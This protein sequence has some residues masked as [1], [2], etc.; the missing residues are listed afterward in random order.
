MLFSDHKALLD[1]GEILKKKP[2]DITEYTIYDRHFSVN[3]APV[4]TVLLADLHNNSFGTDNEALVAAIDEI[5]PEIIWV[6]GDLMVAVPEKSIR[7]AAELMK[8]LAKSYPILYGIGNHEY[9]TRIYPETYGSMYEEYVD[10]LMDAG[11]ELLHNERRTLL[12]GSAEVDVYG[13]EMDRRYYKR[14]S[15]QRMEK[16]YLEEV[17]PKPRGDVYR[18][19]LAHHPKY[20]DT[21]TA[22]GADLTLSGHLHGGIV[23]LFGRGAVSPGLCPFPKY[24]GGRY[25]V[26]GRQLIVSRGLGSHTIPIRINNRPELVVISFCGLT[27]AEEAGMKQIR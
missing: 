6:A 4:K 15:N 5:A 1:V 17:F 25:E 22:W 16:E 14:L 20:A 9:R 26:N 24:S 13:L 18:V 2:F 23:R 19:L 10:C 8:R 12:L 11:V 7:P 27:N 21:Y 3:D